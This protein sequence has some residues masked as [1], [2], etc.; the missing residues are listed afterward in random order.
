MFY[1]K[2]TVSGISSVLSYF[3]GQPN[4]RDD[5][6]V[7]RLLTLNLALA[8]KQDCCYNHTLCSRLF[9][10]ILEASAEAG[11]LF[12]CISIVSKVLL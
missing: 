5:V 11:F 10:I 4:L 8:L 1:R 7:H 9:S 6:K 12:Y 2:R 3:I